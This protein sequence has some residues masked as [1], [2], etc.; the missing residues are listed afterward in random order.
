MAN[1][2]DKILAGIRISDDFDDE[3][4]DEEEEELTAKP[5]RFSA[6]EDEDEPRSFARGKVT[7]MPRTKRSS[8]S[9][10]GMEVC[11]IKP[12]SAEDSKA[13]VDTLLDNR[14]VVINLDGIDVNVAQRIMDFTSG[15]NAALDGH[16][17][18]ISRNIF[19]VTPR[20]V[21]I[22]GDYQDLIGG[23]IDMYDNRR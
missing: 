7:Q 22:S 10:A 3:D 12:S 18:K 6:V 13:I 11:V 1:V 15:A 4:Y 19:I 20:T 5:R 16:L 17:Q 21:E 9:T 8:L 14:T 23:N 2:F